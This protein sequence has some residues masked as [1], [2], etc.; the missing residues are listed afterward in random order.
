[1]NGSTA[2]ASADSAPRDLVVSVNW[3]GDAIM[4]M[5][6]IQLYRRL[7]PG[8]HIT[9][10]ARGAVAD[11]WALH[12][13]PD[14]II[15]YDQR[16]S[17]R[18]PLFATIRSRAFQR[19]WILPNSFRSAWMVYRAGIPERI[20]VPGGLRRILLTRSVRHILPPHQSHQAWEYIKLMAAAATV[21]T[22]PHPELH[23]SAEIKARAI[24]RHGA[25][26][27]PTVGLI[28]GAARG[29]SKR[30]PEAHFLEVARRFIR[31]G[32]HI[33]LFGG[34]DD[35]AV[36]GS[37]ARE[38]GSGATDFSGKTS[39]AE[40]AALMDACRLVAAN[41]SGGMHLAAALGRPVIALYGMTDPSKTGPIGDDCVVL[42]QSRRRSRDVPRNSAEAQRSL[43]AIRPESVYEAAQTLLRSAAGDGRTDS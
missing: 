34:P 30:W 39:L 22:L 2:S 29:P 9:I 36:C 35:R 23:I 26:P 41:D 13:A 25:Y 24:A 5:P 20:G 31:D 4:A 6:A 17:F 42:Q 33:A 14:D 1:M 16:P 38:L 28:P 43:A 8:R 27:G 7:Y 21:D 37:L 10:L 18:D 40:W 3:F 19:A 11:L 32:F 15:R 12:R